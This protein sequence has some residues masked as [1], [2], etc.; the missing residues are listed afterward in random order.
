[1]KN[2]YLEINYVLTTF[3]RQFY[4]ELLEKINTTIFELRKKAE[5]KKKF[6]FKRRDEDFGVQETQIKEEI[7]A[8]E[9]KE[10][11]IPG[12]DGRTS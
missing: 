1:M 2:Y 10:T 9:S 7:K 11:T 4:K 3:D 8:H 6:K 12:I 5:P